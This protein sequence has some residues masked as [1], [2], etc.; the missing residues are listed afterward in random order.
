[1]PNQESTFI[2]GIQWTDN[3]LE[4]NYE[5]NMMRVDSRSGG[6]LRVEYHLVDRC[7]LNCKSCSHYSNIVKD[8]VDKTIDKIKSDFDDLYEVTNKGDPTQLEKITIMGGEPLLYPDIIP[9]MIYIKTKFNRV[10]DVQLLTNGTLLNRM[11]PEFF[12]TLRDLEL[13]VCVS[14]YKYIKYDPI[15]EILQ[16]ENIKFYSYIAGGEPGSQM[17]ASKWLHSHY[18][19]E[20][21]ESAQECL[22]RK[23][24]TQL[25]DGKIYLCPLIAYF[26][27]FDKHCDDVGYKHNFVITDEDSIDL[28]EVASWDELQEE[29]GKVPHFCGYC[30]G[31]HAISQ[32]WDIT[33]R[34]VSE[35]VHDD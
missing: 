30:R 35:W 11:S 26:K 31:S 16:R 9:A 14:I 23:T 7:N 8:E 29:R 20:D 17:F 28:S 4:P 12:Q 13:T 18:S 27:H 32:P 2:D 22:W 10:P 24:C 1:M 33:K 5:A 34:E 21:R 3:K 19:E 15:M 6:A 25:V